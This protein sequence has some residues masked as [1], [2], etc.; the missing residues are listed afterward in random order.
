LAFNCHKMEAL[1]QWLFDN[2]HGNF[3]MKYC[4]GVD[5]MITI[6]CDFLQFSVKN[7]RFSQKPMLWSKFFII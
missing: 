2:R 7:W 3:E 1:C 5:V 4:P 6:F